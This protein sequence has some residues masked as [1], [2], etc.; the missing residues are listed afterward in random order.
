MELLHGDFTRGWASH[1]QR[2]PV[3]RLE[4]TTRH[5][6]VP[7]WDGAPLTGALLLWPEQGLGD[8]LQFVRFVPDVVQR[9]G[10]AARVVL[11]TPTPLRAL[12]RAALPDSIEVIDADDAPPPIAAHAPLLS[13]PFLLDLGASLRAERVPYLHRT[14]TPPAVLDTLLP[15]AQA[16]PLRVGFVW[17]GQPR[18]LNDRNRSTTLETLEPLM[19]IPGIQPFSL[20]KGAG[21]DRIPA[22]NALRQSAGKSPL[23]AL[24]H[25]FESFADTAHAI[26][27]LD[28]VITV[29]TAVAHLAGAMGCAVWLLIPFVPDWR[30]Q[31]GRS[32]S[33]WYGSVRL[34]RQTARG[35]WSAVITAAAQALA[36]RTP[37][38]RQA[39]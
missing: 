18:H 5:Y 35:D 1:E 3:R 7:R 27:R 25:T 2:A 24:G 13:L 6:A 10:P 12:V 23:I 22:F 19:D 30:W 14:G 20:Q 9:A 17:A 15:E 34:F 39:A 31:I 28:L 8:F 38:A 16:E 33:P 32:D 37:R 26:S 36:A 11:A 21:E 29:D 4:Q